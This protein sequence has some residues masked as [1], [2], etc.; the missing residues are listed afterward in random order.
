MGRRGQIVRTVHHGAACAI[1]WL[2]GLAFALS[3][4]VATAV[5]IEADQAL[6]PAPWTSLQANDGEELFH[7]VVVADRTGGERPGVFESAIPKVNLLE[8]AFV[9]S[10][11]DLIEGYTEDQAQLDREWDEFERFVAGLETPFFYVAGNHDMNNARMAETWQARFG[12]SYYRFVYKDVLFLVLNSELFGMVTEP[13]KPVPGPWTQAEQLAFIERALDEFP[14]PRWTIVLIHQPLWDYPGGARGDWPRVEEMLGERDYTVFAGHFHRY[15]KTVRRDRKYVTLATTGGGSSL[16][17]G[18]YGEFDHVAWVTMTARGPRIANLMLS[19]IHDE[20]VVT[21]A[22][23]RATR[24]LVGQGLAAEPVVRSLAPSDAP[25]VEADTLFEKGAVAFL[26]HNQSADEVVVRY[27]VDGG[28]DMRYEGTPRPLT[29][30]PGAAERIELPLVAD[31]PVAYGQLAPGRVEWTL[32]T[33][34]D[35]ETERVEL[36]SALLP[37]ARLRIPVGA[38]T[39]DGDLREWGELPFNVMRQG[40]VA[41]GRTAATDIRFSFGLRESDGDLYLAARVGDDALV[42]SEALA[43]DVQDALVLFA[44]A[45]PDPE[46]SANLPLY[47]AGRLGHLERMAIARMTLADAEPKD[48]RL[49]ASIAAVD[50]RATRTADG[51]VVEAV[52]SGAFLSEQAGGDWRAVRI[53]LVAVDWDEGESENRIPW[54]VPGSSATALHWRPD[55]FGAAPLAG[56]GT[57]VRGEAR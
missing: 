22:S 37:P 32:E 21:E 45:R 16:R 54:H 39:V 48:K 43:P 27:H 7:F 11:G 53:G 55:R 8:P 40:D 28:A 17:G 52:V 51:Y 9:V 4:D 41:S 23:R 13:D 29:L 26:A 3:A 34:A 38:V 36:A 49:A 44:D 50:W 31:P 47:P 12:P 19:G 14:A 30:A 24:A 25:T 18:I 57:F 6:G 2:A 5:E 15:V 10:V 56:T 33:A 1:A 46:R 42:A 35:G 20:N